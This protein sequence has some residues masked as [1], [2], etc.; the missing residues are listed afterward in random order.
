MRYAATTRI[1]FGRLVLEAGDTADGVELEAL[2][3]D[4]AVLLDGGDIVPA[5]D[6]L[7]GDADHP[8]GESPAG[9]LVQALDDLDA[10]ELAVAA[11][12]IARAPAKATQ[13]GLLGLAVQ[14]ILETPD[15]SQEAGQTQ[16]AGTQSL[17]P[18]S[19]SDGAAENDGGDRVVRIRGAVATLRELGRPEDFTS[20]GPA[21][22]AVTVAAIEAATKLDV[23]AA[24]RDAAEAWW[25]ETFGAGAGE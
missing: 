14:E 24:E 4:I 11:A 22:G 17:P 9:R 25:Q 16:D 23:S 10:D 2:G 12:V 6:A 3:A 19:G 1:S 13:L 18:G 20:G 15:A 21:E 7:P 5:T 8:P